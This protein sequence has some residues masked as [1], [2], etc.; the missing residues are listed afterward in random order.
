[1]KIKLT[2]HEFSRQR[3]KNPPLRFYL[4]EGMP[5]VAK[6][7]NSYGFDTVT[8]EIQ[9]GIGAQDHEHLLEAKKQ[10]RIFVTKDIKRVKKE[11][12]NLLN[13]PGIIGIE[14]SNPTQDEIIS[15]M[16]AILSWSRK[17]YHFYERVWLISHD[18]LFIWEADGVVKKLV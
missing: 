12:D 18:S 4:D 15:A 3:R 11:K 13:C 6:Y 16:N 17:S 14:S 8:A 1:M 5:D 10:F 7:L 9:K 2:K